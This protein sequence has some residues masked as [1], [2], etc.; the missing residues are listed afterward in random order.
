MSRTVAPCLRAGRGSQQAQ[1]RRDVP[2]LRRL[3]PASGSDEDRN[4]STCLDKYGRLLGLR[5]AFGQGED[6][7]CIVPSARAKPKKLRP[8]SG[9]GE[10]RNEMMVNE[11]LDAF[12]T[13][14]RFRYY[15]GRVSQPVAWLRR[16]WN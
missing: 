3:R 8:A 6:R 2:R 10:D 13:S 1:P 15:T 7:N 5:P 12:G 9:Q 11:D 14:P 16:L 4:E